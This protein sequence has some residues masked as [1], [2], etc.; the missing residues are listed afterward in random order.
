MS[1]PQVPVTVP[2]GCDP[3][4]TVGRALTGA[5]A[6][7]LA[8][9][10]KALADPVRLRVLSAIAARAGGE[11]CVCDVSDGLDV[12]QPTISHHLK[13]LR[14]AGLVTSERRASWVYYRVVPEALQQLSLVLGRQAGLEVVS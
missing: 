14:E 1:K 5:E 12:T 4:P 2:V 10:F 8:V 13:V 11:A 9:M 7:D 3:T 6:T